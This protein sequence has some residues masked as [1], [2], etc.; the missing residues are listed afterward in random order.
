MFFF[1]RRKIVLDLFTNRQMIYDA[2]KPKLAA[3]FYPD[4]WKELKTELPLG[5]E[6]FSTATMRRCM[7][8]VDHYK[9]GFV[10]PM[11]SDFRVELG[12]VDSPFWRAQFSDSTTRI[13]EHPASL[14][15]S[16]LPDSHYQHLK[17]FTPWSAKCKEDVYWKWEQPTWNQRHPNKAI[18]LPG[19]IEYKYQYSMNTNI[20]FARQHEQTILEIPFQQPLVHVTPLTERDLDLRYHMVDQAEY[21][22][23]MQGEKLSNINRYRSYRRV[24]ESEERKCPFGFGSK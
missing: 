16:Y 2:A 3:Q 22:R 20:M 18:I 1:K 5:D 8:F 6:L 9:H 13:G 24:R 11:W 23:L 14:R 21:D 19:T 17:L 4:W 7:G 12:P 10:I 15:G